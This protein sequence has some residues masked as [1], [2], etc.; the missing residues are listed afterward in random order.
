MVI[1]AR[2]GTQGPSLLALEH[3]IDDFADRLPAE[4]AAVTRLLEALQEPDDGPGHLLVHRRRGDSP[5]RRGGGMRWLIQLQNH[6]ADHRRFDVDGEQ[7]ERLLG[8]RLGLAL[9]R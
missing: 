2:Q 6:L 9:G 1:T 7:E 3:A 5:W 4:D 8:A